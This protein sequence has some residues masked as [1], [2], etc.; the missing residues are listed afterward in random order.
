MCFHTR[1][2]PDKLVCLRGKISEERTILIGAAMCKSDDVR[3][4][5]W[6]LRQTSIGEMFPK[7][8]QDPWNTC[9][10]WK[11][12]LQLLPGPRIMATNELQSENKTETNK[13]LNSLAH[14]TQGISQYTGIWL[15]HLPVLYQMKR[16]KE[17]SLLWQEFKCS[18]ITKRKT[19]R[20][21]SKQQQIW[22]FPVPLMISNQV[23]SYPQRLCTLTIYSQRARKDLEKN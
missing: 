1:F 21:F 16:E 10:W 19:I 12:S 9:E 8:L 18:R 17:Q 3:G 5:V 14:D 15:R 6:I 11:I 20:P 13:R 2:K 4:R 22:L 7:C 23:V